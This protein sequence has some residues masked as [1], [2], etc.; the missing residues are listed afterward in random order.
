MQREREIKEEREREV[1]RHIRIIDGRMWQFYVDK[2]KRSWNEARSYCK[3]LTLLG[4]SDWRLPNREELNAVRTK[5][6]YQNTLSNRKKTHI[7]KALLESM[8]MRSQWFWSETQ[9]DASLSWIVDFDH[10]SDRYISN[11]FGTYVRCFRNVE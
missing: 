8:D 10:G 4:Y 2:K 3:N 11:S 1:A 5:Q 9:K 6:A 7:V